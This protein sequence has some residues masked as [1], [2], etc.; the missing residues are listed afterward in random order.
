MSTTTRGGSLTSGRGGKSPLLSFLEGRGLLGVVTVFTVLVSLQLSSFGGGADDAGGVGATSAS[1]GGG[2]GGSR[3]TNARRRHGGNIAYELLELELQARMRGERPSPDLGMEGLNVAKVKRLKATACYKG[4]E[5]D[6]GLCVEG[7]CVCPPLYSGPGCANFT[8]MPTKESSEH[9]ASGAAPPLGAWCGVPFDHPK[10][11][12]AKPAEASGAPAPLRTFLSQ[13]M[14]RRAP[15][16]PS[17]ADF[18]TCAVVGSSGSLLERRMGVEIESHTAV[19]R[20]NDAPTQGY[21]AHVGR[22]TTLRVQNIAYCGFRERTTEISLHYTDNR[23]AHVGTVCT[24]P[25]I[26]RISP[27]MLSYSKSY[28]TRTRP[29]PPEDPTAGKAK[30]SGRG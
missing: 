26:K 22:K 4:A 28:W 7:R 8:E 16:L 9:G 13:A 15:D 25:H 29:P 5:C 10:F 24:D 30:L 14:K 21:E 20:V 3:A 23:R 27:R 17:M 19:F 12:P 2:W 6:S 11:F 18:S 1:R